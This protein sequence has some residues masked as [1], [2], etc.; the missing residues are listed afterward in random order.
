MMRKNYSFQDG[1]AGSQT[2]IVKDLLAYGKKVPTVLNH[3]VAQAFLECK[4]RIVKV[5]FFI[6]FLLYVIFLA[7]YSTFLGIVFFRP[8]NN[9]K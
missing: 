5:Y 2:G 7:S 3:P 1:S 4:W 6:T 9:L 8:Q